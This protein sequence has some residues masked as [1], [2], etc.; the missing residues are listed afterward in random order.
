MLIVGMLLNKTIKQA[1][2]VVGDWSLVVG[3]QWANWGKGIV[4]NAPDT[5]YGQAA[6]I[7]VGSQ[8]SDVGKEIVCPIYFNE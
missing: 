1:Y 2:L 7:D 6:E 4:G 8:M 5:D 3:K